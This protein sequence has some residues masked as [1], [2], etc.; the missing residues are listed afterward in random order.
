MRSLRRKR[1]KSSRMNS[2]NKKKKYTSQG[3]SICKISVIY[4]CW[5]KTNHN[6][7]FPLHKKYDIKKY[8]IYNLNKS[9]IIFLNYSLLGKV[10]NCIFIEYS[11]SILHGLYSFSFLVSDI[12][13]NDCLFIPNPKFSSNA[14]TISTPSNESNPRSSKDA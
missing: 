12:Q 4:F 13:N 2:Q 8:I 1:T 5:M 7:N 14:T 3:Y 6:N 10:L 9:L 11:Y